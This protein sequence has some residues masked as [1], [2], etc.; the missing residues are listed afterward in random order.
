MRRRIRL[1]GRKQIPA[2][3]FQVSSVA[4]TGGFKFN[5]Q[6]ES[7]FDG[8]DGTAKVRLRLVENKV[9]E[10]IELGTVSHPS[11]VVGAAS[12][13]FH[14][15][16]CQ[17]RVVAAGENAGLILGST[18]TWTMKV[19]GDEDAR[20]EGILHFQRRDQAPIVWSL[21]IREDDHPV[22][23]L[24]NS[25]PDT[26]S[27]A[28]SNPVFAAL[29]FPAILHR[30]YSEILASHCNRDMD[31]VRDWEQLALQLVP[32]Q[33]LPYEAEPADIEDWI[34]LITESFSRQHR[35]LE[36]LIGDTTEDNLS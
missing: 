2:S 29:V 6:D 32:G 1:T 20:A 22:V 26:T 7:I 12:H 16:A 13:R 23:Y 19:G 11:A 25:I 24:D 28:R 36:R 27:W 9:A 18:D 33:K 10:V 21:D 14:A 34:S 3:S 8:F 4:G 35:L 31:W 15:P 30:I 5:I 17:L